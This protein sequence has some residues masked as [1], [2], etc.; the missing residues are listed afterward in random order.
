MDNA[1]NE[2][3]IIV[4]NRKNLD[5]ELEK[6]QDILLTFLDDTKKLE[7]AIRAIKI[8]LTV[9]QNEISKLCDQLSKLEQDRDQKYDLA[10]EKSA[11][12]VSDWDGNPIPLKRKETVEELGMLSALIIIHLMLRSFLFIRSSS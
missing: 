9:K 5:I 1:K 11:E 2:H 6:Q 8:E 4:R 3:S 12:L 7:N 10:M